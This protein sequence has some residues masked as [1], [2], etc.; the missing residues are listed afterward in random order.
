MI[1]G[2]YTREGLT[3]KGGHT[4]KAWAY[5]NKGGTFPNTPIGRG[6]QNN[7]EFIDLDELTSM[8]E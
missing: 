1:K 5:T 7:R 2:S 8:F 6:I 3:N 4:R